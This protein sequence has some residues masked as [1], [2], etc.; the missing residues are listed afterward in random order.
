MSSIV[1]HPTETAQW[2]A[3]VNEAERAASHQLP[4]DLE[5]YLVFL[6][7]RFLQRPDMSSK[8][9]ATEYL[10][11]LLKQGQERSNGLRDVGDQCLLVSGLFPRRAERRRVKVSYFVDLG[12]SAY[13]Q[14]FSENNSGFNQ[15]Y[16]KLSTSF[17][18]MMDILH[19]LRQ[20]G[21]TSPILAPL[22]AVELWQDTGSR[23]AFDSLKTISPICQ[24]S[25][26]PKQKQ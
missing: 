21:S 24:L 4:E 12:R 8:I 25:P 14:L 22:D 11:S 1:L 23:R 16:Q 6:L 2:H 19:A 18:Q 7:M 5:S 20:L 9:F 15:I 17:V 3:L 26:E 10:E 13:G